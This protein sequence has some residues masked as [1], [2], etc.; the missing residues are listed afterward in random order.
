[1]KFEYSILD[2]RDVRKRGGGQIT[3]TTLLL[4]L[5]PDSVLSDLKNVIFKIQTSSYSKTE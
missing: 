2:N 5:P 4:A 1:M 3:P